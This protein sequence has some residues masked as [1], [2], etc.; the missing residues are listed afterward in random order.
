MSQICT[1]PLEK[2][3]RYAILAQFHMLQVPPGKESFY[4]IYVEKMGKKLARNWTIYKS[5][6]TKIPGKNQI[7]KIR[8][9]SGYQIPI[10]LCQILRMGTVTY[11]FMAKYGFFHAIFTN[12]GFFFV[13]IINSI[14]MNFKKIN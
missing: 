3:F 2:T 13:T 4:I 7:R 12:F 11:C 10:I 6:Q 14:H 5:L 1:P 9:K 8:E